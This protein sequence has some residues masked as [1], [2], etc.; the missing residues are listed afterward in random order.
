MNSL[1]QKTL[2]QVI[3]QKV[4]E[5][6]EYVWGAIGRDLKPRFNP[7]NTEAVWFCIERMGTYRPQ[8]ERQL[9]NIG[10]TYQVAT[11]LAQKI[12]LI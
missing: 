5:D 2:E 6:V 3:D 11:Y 4:I 7:T 10:S 8:T 1:N 9:F 12:N